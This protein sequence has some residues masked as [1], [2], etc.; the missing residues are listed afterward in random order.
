MVD[1]YLDNLKKL[2]AI[3]LDWGRNEQFQNV[4]LTK[5][6]SEK[7]E[8]LAIQIERRYNV[9]IFFRDPEIRNYIFSGVLKDENLEQVLRIIA[10]TSPIEYY[11][12][13]QSV[14][15]SNKK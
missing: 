14:Y 6:F 2:K 9:E 13:N 12:V 1:D 5:Q 3:K 7:L 11:M 15:L 4:S 8:D 10:S